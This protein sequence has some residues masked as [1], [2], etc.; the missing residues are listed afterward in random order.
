MLVSSKG[1]RPP[2][3][4]SQ[5]LCREGGPAGCRAQSRRRAA[6][7]A[8]RGA[9]AVRAI[10]VLV[11]LTGCAQDFEPD[12]SPGGPEGA[13]VLTAPLPRTA[14]A[15]P[16]P[17]SGAGDLRVNRRLGT[18]QFVDRE[19]ARAAAGPPV[20]LEGPDRFSINLVDVPIRQAAEAILGDTLGLN[21]A[22]AEDVS[23]AVTVQTSRPL[24][25]ADLYDIFDEVLSLTD[26]AIER[27]DESVVIVRAADAMAGF[28]LANARAPVGAAIIVMPL[29]FVGVAEMRRILEPI[30]SPTMT[31]SENVNRNILFVSGQTRE[32]EA[33]I[34]AV[35]IFD[36]D[37]LEGRSVSRVRLRRATPSTV[38]AELIAVFDTGPGGSL[39]GVLRFVPNDVD[40]SILVISSRR[41]YIAEAEE[42]IRDFEAGGGGQE[43][44]VVVYRLE[45]REAEKLAPVINA[46]LSFGAAGVARQGG[47]GA[48]PEAAAA[49]SAQTPPISAPP[50]GAPPSGAPAI[51]APA[52]SAPAISAPPSGAPASGAP[53]SGALTDEPEAGVPRALGSAPHPLFFARTGVA[54]VPDDISNSIVA[55]ATPAQQEEIA[56]LVRQLDDV[57]AQVLLEATIAEVE[58]RD[59]LD[60]GVR[61]FFESGNFATNFTGIST[62]GVGSLVPG[63]NAV[64]ESGQAAVALDVLSEVTNVNILSSPSL[65]VL[66]N[67]EAELN[68]GAQVPIA[69]S[70]AVDVRDPDAPIVNEIEQ[71]DTGVI[72]NIRPRV[73]GTGRVILEVRQ[74]V[75][76]V[77]ETD[78]SGIDSPTIRQRIVSTTVAV[79]DGQSLVIGGLIQETRSRTQQKVPLLGDIPLLGA[80]FRNTSDND[81]RTELLVIITPRVVRDPLEARRLTEEYRRKLNQ[82]SDLIGAPPS[83]A[84]HQLRRMLF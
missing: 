51:S 9:A 6:R 13:P 76:D 26:L 59:E 36:I 61:F 8:A 42:W 14:G 43:P 5:P 2:G 33:V 37:V 18:D 82:P 19:A 80:V 72:L 10:L 83:S 17:P 66:D 64:F 44:I 3:N 45:N 11:L 49:Q 65:M 47:P 20:I 78:T 28:R 39:E 15:P 46:L 30:V 16:P 56:A 7:G 21:Y 22:V 57:A 4:G 58:L 71:K 12:D 84:G 1:G 79:D 73:S 55:Y 62:L 50:I 40:G 68:V 31:I 53:P 81:L 32:V 48:A 25:R 27:T 67:R 74:E 63:F 34:E 69:V 75:S 60:F 77:V 41:R 52:I 23:G 24:S 70:S 38:A 35:N 54:V 29:R